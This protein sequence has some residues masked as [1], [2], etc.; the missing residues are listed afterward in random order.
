MTN[1]VLIT[2]V[3]F[4]FLVFSVPAILKVGGNSYSAIVVACLIKQGF[5]T[6]LEKVWG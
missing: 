3:L 1:K 6:A 4:I 2:I 5:R